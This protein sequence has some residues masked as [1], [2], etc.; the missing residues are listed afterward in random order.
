MTSCGDAACLLVASNADFL[1]AGDNFELSSFFVA[2]LCQAKLSFVIHLSCT[3]A[4][5]STSTSTFQNS[6][7]GYVGLMSML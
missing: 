7:C 5:V 4:Y 6:Y 3:Y 1:T 2:K